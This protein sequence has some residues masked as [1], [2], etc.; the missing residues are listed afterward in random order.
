MGGLRASSRMSSGDCSD[1]AEEEPS[2]FN[3]EMYEI[4]SKRFRE[5]SW[6]VHQPTGVGIAHRCFDN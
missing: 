6:S 2:Q 4:F 1:A 3:G 5:I